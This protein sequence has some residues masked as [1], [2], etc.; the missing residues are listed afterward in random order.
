MHD[1]LRHE[2]DA[3]LI[4]NDTVS[5]AWRLWT[6]LD[7][8]HREM[9]SASRNSANVCMSETQVTSMN[10]LF[11]Q[12]IGLLEQTDDPKNL[13]LLQTDTC[14]TYSDALLILGQYKAALRSFRVQVLKEG[15]FSF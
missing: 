6:S 2:L 15:P 7:A 9:N 5:T 3:T 1:R 10:G 4:I 8:T 12:I 11:Q 14:N 13:H